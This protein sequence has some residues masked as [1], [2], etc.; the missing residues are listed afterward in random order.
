M[1]IAVF[2]VG[3][4]GGYFGGRLAQSGE[5]VFFIARGEH[6][7]ALRGNGLL[8]ENPDGGV[9]EIPAKATDDPAEVGPVDVVILGVKA[10]QVQEAA[11][12]LRP[13]I[14][15][16]TFVVPLQNG[17]EA[18]SQLAA[19]LGARHV[20]GGLCYIVS[21][22]V[23][24]GRIRHAGMEPR[25]VFGELDNRPSDRAQRLLQSFANAALH[26]E[27]PPDIQAAIWSKFLFISSLSGVGAVTRA[28]VGVVRSIPETR[29][30]L[31]EAIAEAAVVARALKI[32]LKENAV[33]S[34]MA[35]IDALPAGTTASM[36]RD[37]MEGRPSELSAQSGA[38]VRLG[39]EAGQAV[40]LSLYIYSSLLPLEL[41]AR[42]KAEF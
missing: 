31:K 17:V 33:E 40:P 35:V 24:P 7:Q 29:N 14:G 8:L 30:M 3:G 15:P 4:V 39:K 9:T 23:G 11:E 10:W 27:I 20:F 41:R 38:L 13:L 32:G 16:D 2:G 42:G 25:V 26:A 36:Q 18:P 34:T 12:R 19:T 6:L 22:M 28:P 1:R 21:F 5:D 37:I